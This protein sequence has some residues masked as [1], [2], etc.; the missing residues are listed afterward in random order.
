MEHPRIFRSAVDEKY[1]KMSLGARPENALRY[2]AAGIIVPTDISGIE[3][4]VILDEVLG[5]QRVQYNL[6]KACRVIRMDTLTHN[7]DVATKAAAKKK[8]PPMVEARVQSQDYERVPF[9]LWKNVYHV[10]VAD[11]SQKKAAHDIMG[12]NVRD[13]AGA[14]AQAENEQIAVIME[15]GTGTSDGADWG[16]AASGRSTNDPYI[17]IMTAFAT[18]EGT[19]GFEPDFVIA[20]PYVWVDFFGNDFVKGQLQGTVFPGGK[21][22]DLPGLPGM[23]GMSDWGITTTSAIVLDSDQAVV[24]G[25]GPTE[26]ARYRNET[27]GY[28]AY[29][30]RQWLEPLIVQE[31]A[32]F[33]LTTL[34]A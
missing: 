14:L 25:E 22:F 3:A 17:D 33:E 18:I 31:G 10:A 1:Y 30:I 26:A 28:F 5:L 12:L 24:F 9:E 19:W 20:H 4:V 32:I 21:I 23:K 34:N 7:I 8:V 6:R 29:I 13:A 27:A 11:E 15:A 16:A 2:E